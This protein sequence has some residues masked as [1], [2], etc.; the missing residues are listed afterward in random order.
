MTCYNNTKEGLLKGDYV[1]KLWFGNFKFGSGLRVVEL[2]VWDLF[3][4]VYGLGLGALRDL[5]SV[6]KNRTVMTCTTNATGGSEYGK[7]PSP[8]LTVSLSG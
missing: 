6:P 3:F 7:D 8:K 2:W 4:G 5:P 1:E